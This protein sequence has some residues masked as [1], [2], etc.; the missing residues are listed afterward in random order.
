MS[1][2]TDIL[3]IGGGTMGLATAIELARHGAKVTVL[4]QNF[5]Q[6]ALHAAAGMLAPQAENL[7][8][9]PMLELCLRSRSLYPAWIDQLETQTGLECGYWACGILAPVYSEARVPDAS[10]VDQ[11]AGPRQWLDR[12]ALQQRQPGLNPQIPGGWWFPADAQVDNRALA[13]VLQTAAHQLGVA[14]HEPVTVQGWQLQGQRVA[15]VKTNAGEWQAETYILATGAWSGSL[16][17]IPVIPR[18]GQMLALQAPERPEAVQPLRQVIFGD[19]IYL[20]PRCNG[21][22]VIGATNE[23]VGFTPDNT[24]AGLRSLLAGAMDL[25]PPLGDWP[26]QETWWGFRPTTPDELPILGWGPYSN[27]VLATGHHRNGILLAPLTAQLITDLVIQNRS[28]PLLASF[29]WSRLNRSSPIGEVV[30]R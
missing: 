6:A 11:T 24:P 3:V 26:I 8:G 20:V 17:P 2:K 15:T 7:A 16:L 1:S 23:Q 25:Y 12:A 27:L 9:G 5:A 13:Q 21:R 10:L 14:I 19:G 4:S 29:D 28:D 30:L 22:L 18:K